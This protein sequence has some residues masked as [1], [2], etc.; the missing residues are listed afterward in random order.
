M[1]QRL[2]RETRVWH[3]LSHVNILPFLGVCGNIGPSSAMISPLCDNGNVCQYLINEPEAD[4]DAIVSAVYLHE[5]SGGL[6]WLFI[7]G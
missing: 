7:L 6:N 3:R 2:N 1:H 5:K 4:R